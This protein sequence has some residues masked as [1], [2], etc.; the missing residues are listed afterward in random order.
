MKQRTAAL[1]LLL[2]FLSDAFAGWV[3]NNPYPAADAHKKIYYSSFNEQPKTLDPARSYASNEYQFLFQIYEPLLR[4]DYYKR[5][6]Q[7]IPLTV[8]EMPGLRFLDKQGKV[9]LEPR[10]EDIDFSVYTIAIKSGIRFQPHPAFAKDEQGHYR[11]LKLSKYYVK[12]QEIKTLKD[13]FFTGSRELTADDYIYEIKRL[14]NPAINS[15]VYGLMSDRIVGFHDYGTTLPKT[16]SAWVDLR[17]YPMSGLKKLDDYHF[18]ITLKGRYPQFRFWLAMPFFA[19]VPWEADAFYSQPGMEAVNLNLDWYPVGTGPFLLSENNP[20]RQMVLSRNPNFRQEYFPVGGSAEDISKGYQHDVGKALPLIDEARYMLEKESIPRWNKFLQGYYD[21]SG[22]TN[23]G[24]DQAITIDS[25]GKPQLSESM[26]DKKMHLDKTI[27]PSINYLGFNMRDSLVG[28]SSERARKLRQ[29]I[30]IAIKYDENIAIFLNGR[31]HPAQG[32]I[33]PGIFGYKEGAAGVNPYVY[34]WQHN[35]LKRR[36]IQDAQ[37][38]MKAA[39]YPG[40][41]DPTTGKALILNYDVIITGSPDD[42]TQLDWMR[43]QFARIGVDLNIRGTLY[44]RFQEKM[45][46]GNAQVFSWGWSADYPDPENF[47]YLLYGANGKVEFGGENASN[48]KNPSYDKLFELMKN[49]PDNQERQNLIDQ[50]VEIARKDA[51]LVWG[52]NPETL[53]MAQQ[54]VSPVKPNGISAN[55]LK[56]TA[57]DVDARSRLRSVWNQPVI[58]PLLLMMVFIILSLLPLFFAYARKEKSKAPRIPLC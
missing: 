4:Y 55:Y 8:A 12:Q 37:Q 34:Q 38:L 27:D 36:G 51:P 53:L 49:L 30:S 20:N 15:P 40:G 46:N 16:A 14:A 48:Y 45:R 3:L 25:D 57:V 43:K 44:N 32:P 1:V 11:Y 56:Y 10:E 9:L 5:P 22:I 54:W 35:R 33:P 39:G 47:L 18:E 41:I 29:A 31:G 7:L 28:G 50:M 42:Q 2:S 13:F 19:P 21:F 17:K 58:W 6:Y 24:F 52:I 23:E 26:R